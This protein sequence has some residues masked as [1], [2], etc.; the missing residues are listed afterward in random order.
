MDA[1]QSY[2]LWT[3]ARHLIVNE[4][5]RPVDAP[6]V[7]EHEIWLEKIEEPK[8]P[9]VRLVARQVDWSREVLRDRD[10][11]YMMVQKLRDQARKRK[12]S[13][14]NVYFCPLPPVDDTVPPLEEPV[15]ST[16]GAENVTILYTNEGDVRTLAHL[17][18]LLRTSLPS[19]EDA[20]ERTEAEA[21]YRK[22]QALQVTHVRM[23]RE[24]SFFQN[25]KP[26]MTYVFIAIQI[27]MFAILEWNGGS[28]N[29]E[30]LIRYGAKFQPLILEGEWWRLLTAVFLHIGF[31]H[32]LM[33]T[34]ALFYLGTAV[35]RIFGTIRFTC[36][37]LLA[38]VIGSLASFAFTTNLS[39][40]AS[41]AIFGCFGA[42]LYIGVSK[43][44][45]FFRTMG[46]NV[47]FILA[48][49]LMF[50]FTIPGID[51]AGHLGG[52]VGG[53]LI[54][55]VV[56]F[57][58]QKSKLR[59]VPVLILLFIIPFLVKTGI[60]GEYDASKGSQVVALAQ[61]YI[62]EGKVDQAYTLLSDTFAN[63]EDVPSEAY[64]F[65]AYVELKRADYKQAE[66]HLL[67]AIE[68]DPT[69]TEAYFNLAVLYTKT[70]RFPE[71]LDVARK[72]ET[73]DSDNEDIQE[74]LQQLTQSLDEG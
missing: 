32:L 59:L 14:V 45:L 2:Q 15:V 24:Q 72:A 60:E 6:H 31:L 41:G 58:K 39:A 5:Y 28:Q 56:H 17:S 36:I 63:Q 55:A 33:N 16:R 21:L 3:V 52:L 35:E 26:R 38:G 65:L 46:L 74:L 22:Q 9:V 57:P 70:N 42:L 61:M 25:G 73:L 18:Q 48:L 66:G 50:G 23:K 67:K 19:L 4:G 44:R 30:T 10:R 54:A 20:E 53:F 8:R 69:F 12:V 1:K 11:A 43:P 13:F 34:L 47:L 49:N 29:T 27:V 62:Q 68:Q 40:G 64:F 7:Q 51:N 71:A 37:Y